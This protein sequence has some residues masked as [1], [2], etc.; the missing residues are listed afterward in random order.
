M[1]II[2]INQFILLYFS[3]NRLTIGASSIGRKDYVMIV[4]SFIESKIEILCV[5]ALRGSY[6]WRACTYRK[7]LAFSFLLNCIVGI[8]CKFLARWKSITYSA[9]PVIF[10]IYWTRISSPVHFSNE[11]KRKSYTYTQK[12]YNCIAI[13]KII[14]KMSRKDEIK[15]IRTN[16]G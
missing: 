16:S 14:N 11:R 13:V 12:S 15:K 1:A 7:M 10:M 8:D 5:F 9:N 2:D 3:S 6:A 4:I